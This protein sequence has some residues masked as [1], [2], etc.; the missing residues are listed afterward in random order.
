VAT[1]PRPVIDSV[2]RSVCGRGIERIARLTAGGVNETYRVELPDGA[3]V[4][5]RISRQPVPWFTDEEH[6]MA[7]ARGTGVPTPEVLGVETV[8]HGGE[9]LSFSLQRLVPGRPLDEVAGELVASDLE[10]LVMDGGELLARVHSIGPG[11]GIRHQLRPPDEGFVAGV[12]RVADQAF[13]PAAAAIVERGAD[14]LREEVTTRPAPQLSLGHGDWLPQHLVVDDGAIAGV[15]DW[16]FAGPAPPARDLA[17]WEVSAGDRPHHRSDLLR[18]GYARPRLG[19]RGL[20]AGLR[21]RLG[22]GSARLE[23]PRSAG[24]APA[25]CGSARPLRRR[26]RLPRAALRHGHQ[27]SPAR[28]FPAAVRP[29]S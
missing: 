20:G 4:V 29:F 26:H 9:P 6:L 12:V 18:R 15:I 3:V 5:V 28:N 27:P 1:T 25:L 10:R 14:V 23:E 13:G 8:D 2:V 24:A 19:R 7:Q 17:R 16:E 11:R 21:H 22:A